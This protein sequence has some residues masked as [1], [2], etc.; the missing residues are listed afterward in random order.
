MSTTWWWR[1]VWSPA[2]NARKAPV[3]CSPVSVS[4]FSAAVAR[5]IQILQNALGTNNVIPYCYYYY[6]YY[7]TYCPELDS[8]YLRISAKYLVNFPLYLFLIPFYLKFYLHSF[9]CPPTPRSSHI[10]LFAVGFITLRFRISLKLTLW[11][12][13]SDDEHAIQQKA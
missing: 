4:T 12:F 8:E 2:V 9:T 11:G 6:Y 1:W 10:L 5:N 13:R 3:L 7:Y